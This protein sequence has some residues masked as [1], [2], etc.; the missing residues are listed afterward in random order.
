MPRKARRTPR[1]RARAP[2]GASPARTSL[3]AFAKVAGVSQ[4]ALTKAI[5]SG[6]LS[7]PAIGRDGKGAPYIADQE[8]ALRQLRE[9]V[10][11]LAE[12]QRRV[13]LQREIKLDLENR[14]SQGRL[15][16]A[17]R[18]RREFFE[19]GRTFRE[20]MLGIPDRY[21]SQLA[22]EGDRAK[23]HELL[24]EAIRGALNVLAERFEN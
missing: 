13:A 18:C 20:A 17:E 6:R 8:E 4:P 1:K 24:D 16:D 5:Q 9:G 15:V 14:L 11:S 12:A 22:A 21:A 23:V 7:D 2:E 19:A 10:E 3:R